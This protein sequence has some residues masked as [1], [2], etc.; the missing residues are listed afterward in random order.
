MKLKK[1]CIQKG[2]KRYFSPT[3]NNQTLVL[4]FL[5][6]SAGSACR[7]DALFHIS[8]CRL[9]FP[10]RLNP[11][12]EN[13]LL[14]RSLSFRSPCLQVFASATVEISS[15]QASATLLALLAHPT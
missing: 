10:S 2:L 13:L 6:D 3:K 12:R 11:R 9:R 8:N 7:L 15:C 14:P 4:V 5:A 1:N